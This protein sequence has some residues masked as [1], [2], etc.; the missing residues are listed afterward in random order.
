MSDGRSIL[1]TRVIKATPERIWRCWTDPDLLPQ[2][3]GPQGFSCKTKEI[4]LREGGHWLF[5]MIGPQGEIYPNLHRYLRYV[6]FER[7]EFN[8]YDPGVDAVHAEVLVTLTPVEGGTRFTQEMTFAD[9][10][11]RDA[12]VN[13][14][15]VEYGNTTFAKLAALAES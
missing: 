7:I 8:M 11:M 1:M 14:G 9:R 2:W 10:A 6:P 4:D 5:D 3:F 13:F 15:A 12:V